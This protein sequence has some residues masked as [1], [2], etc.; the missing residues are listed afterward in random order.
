MKM[1]HSLHRRGN[2]A[3]LHE[4]YV[5]LGIPNRGKDH[6]LSEE[7]Q[8]NLR[9]IWEILSRYE[10]DLA[11]FG[12]GVGRYPMEVLKKNK[13]K[14]AVMVAFKDRETLKSC[15]REIKDRNL[16]IS[17]VLSGIYEHTEELCKEL[18]LSPHTVEHSLDIHGKTERLPEES[19]LEITTL[20]GHA[21]ASPNLVKHLVER[22]NEGKITHAE[23]AEELSRMCDCGIFN[24]HRAEKILRKLTSTA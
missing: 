3:D 18:G 11:N 9:Q 24:P 12:T 20:C 23:A 4:D 6:S 14:K 10:Q 16:G 17:I 13:S 15:L 21:M 2:V 8:E 5:V 7:S 1:T 19:V 22:I